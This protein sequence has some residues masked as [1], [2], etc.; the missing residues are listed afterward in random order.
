MINAF[1]VEFNLIFIQEKLQHKNAIIKSK[2]IKN[3]KYHIS[4]AKDTFACFRRH[5]LMAKN[6]YLKSD[7]TKNHIFNL[8]S[9]V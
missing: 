7:M 3:I 8:N 9:K 4:K 5:F 1:G 6:V 2:N